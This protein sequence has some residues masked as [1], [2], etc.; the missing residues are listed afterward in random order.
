MQDLKAGQLV[1]ATPYRQQIM[2]MVGVLGAAFVLPIVLELLNNSYGIGPRTAEHPYSL[3]APQA[4]MMESVARGVFQQNLPWGMI[5]IGAGIAVLIII[6]DQILKHRGSSFRMPVL[7]VAIGLYLPIEPS[8]AIFLGGMLAVIIRRMQKKRSHG[9]DA[10][11]KKSDRTGLLFASGLITEEALIGIVL[12][13][14]V[15]VSGDQNVLTLVSNPADSYVGLL[16][17]L[18]ICWMLYNYVR[19]SLKNSLND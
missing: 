1:G 17:L 19:R 11:V 18:G 14:P 4:G 10:A 2:Q 16:I 7:A 6:A 12:A 8:S 5:A 9:N 15:A 13:I 3:T